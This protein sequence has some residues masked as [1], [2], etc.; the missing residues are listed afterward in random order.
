M[1]IIKVRGNI[2][3]IFLGMGWDKWTRIRFTDGRIFKLDGSSLTALEL[4]EVYVKLLPKVQ[5]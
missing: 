2:F 5:A 3:D 1:K 4:K